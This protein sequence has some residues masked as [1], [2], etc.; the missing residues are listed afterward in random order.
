MGVVNRCSG[1]L[2]LCPK[3]AQTDY[4]QVARKDREKDRESEMDRGEKNTKK[5]KADTAGGK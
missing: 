1:T 4:F 5:D 2:L 3:R